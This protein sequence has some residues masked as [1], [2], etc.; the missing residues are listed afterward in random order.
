M[1]VFILKLLLPLVKFFAGNSIDYDKLK[2]IVETKLLMDR[3]RKP[4]SWKPQK[5]NKSKNPLLTTL[6]MNMLVSILFA[7]PIFF[8]DNILLVGIL[9]H[10]YLLFMLMMTLITDFSSVLLDTADN[11]IILPRPVSGR[12]LFVAR[13]LH[14]SVYLLQFTLSL[15]LLPLIALF[16][17]FGIA[18]SLVGFATLLLTASFAVFFTYLLYLLLF[19]FFS[20][21]K[22]KSI[23]TY[24]QIFM[25]IVLLGSYQILPRLISFEKL[26]FN[27]TLSSYAYVLPPV[28][29]SMSMEAVYLNNYNKLHLIMMVC[30]LLAPII[31]MWFMTKYLAPVFNKKIAALGGSVTSNKITEKSSGSDTALSEKLSALFCSNQLQ[32]AG[33]EKVWKITGRDKNFKLQFYPSLGYIFVL[34]FVV[35]FKKDTDPENIMVGLK[36]G[37][38]F[39]LFIYLPLFVLYNTLHIIPFNQNY[40]AAWIYKSA[41]INQPG[42]IITGS[43][44]ALFVKFFLPLFLIFFS[45][46]LY[47]WGYAIIDDF[48]YGLLNTIFLFILLN[49]LGDIYLPFSLKPDVKKQAGKVIKI[50]IQS[51]AIAVLIG[52][53]YF[54]LKVDYLLYALMPV[55]IIGILLLLKKLKNISWKKI[56]I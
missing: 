22:I 21:Q 30:A 8:I 28:W 51:I 55:W 45:L 36:N 20:E 52:L 16:I 44:K 50:I 13:L 38:S 48:I 46:C 26:S 12:T 47:I 9:M 37:K 1:D 11:Q 40:E 18:A 6:L 10:T 15:T 25:T 23:V 33:F 49:F 17:N 7:L 56:N 5:E 24:F 54:V 4:L 29:M 27:F 34:M 14:I 3:R 53:H 41:P 43:L 19:Y 31:I 39:L 42:Q 2:I 35:L 32:V